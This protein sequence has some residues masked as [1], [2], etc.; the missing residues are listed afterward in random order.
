MLTASPRN[1]TAAPEV[2]IKGK[3]RIAIEAVRQVENGVVQV[4]GQLVDL[5]T[6]DGIGQQRLAIH[7]GGVFVSVTTGPDGRFLATFPGS[8]GPQ[9]LSVDY[10]GGSLIDPAS[11]IDTVDPSRAEV[12]L[13]LR[14]EPT[15]T[16]V[17]LVVTATSQATMD[18]KLD[19]L[20]VELSIGSPTDA[21]LKPLA[22]VTSEQ[23]FALTRAAAGG[24]GTRRI[25]A[26]FP[27]TPTQQPATTDL[28]LELTA[29][30]TTTMKLSATRLAHEDDLVVAGS[31]IDED[32]T[33]VPRAAITLSA[34]DRRLAQGATTDAGDYRLTV[35]AEVLGPGD[36]GLQVAADPS[37]PFLRP[38]RANPAT[39]T[40]APPQPVP[41][42]YTIAAF[43]ATAL[44][45]AGFFIARAKP[46]ERFRKASPAAEA[47]EGETE[48]DQTSGGL[49]SNR[50]GIVSTLR[51]AADDSFTGAVRDTVRGRP[52]EGALV[53]VT[54]SL[55]AVVQEVV[56]AADGTFAFEQLAAG[57]WRAEV[58]AIGHVTEQFA[59]AIPHRG[60]L[61]GVRVDL[62]PIRERVFQ[63]YRRAAEPTL[64]ETRLWGI[65]SPRQI[66][67]HVRA[68]KPSPA[69]A[70]LT[71]LVEE[72]Y[73]SARVA[74]ESV[75]GT[76]AEHVDL[77]IK[78]RRPSP[79]P[80]PAV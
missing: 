30:T 75:I 63:L 77:A 80:P 51:R 4:N 2:Q 49:V 11:F 44:A 21:T 31:V 23:P 52:V 50:P 65:W 74:P 59:L 10:G 19:P 36:F 1:A 73:F 18:G 32:G 72:V 47:P 25:R 39:I 45:A 79:A 9:P 56:T 29:A 15:P 71:D 16:G 53:R 22:T 26:V 17:N 61:R 34:G 27:G 57:E 7:L 60:E 58:G 24:T 6:G 54:A 5:L 41:V 48:Q 33:P 43:A 78:E 38:S 69:L 35:E 20:P 55:G 76:A 28:T 13:T 62:V 46:W 12:Q 3:T 68:R 42:V 67:D 66:V 40:V 14:A 8:V 64:P 37:T 70:A